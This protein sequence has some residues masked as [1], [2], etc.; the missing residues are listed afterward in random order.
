M[1]RRTFL[2]IGVTA[3]VG[4]GLAGCSGDTGDNASTNSPPPTQNPETATEAEPTEQTEEATEEPVDRPTNYRWDMHPGRNDQLRAWLNQYVKEPA[5]DVIQTHPAFEYSTESE[6]D[7]HE[8]DFEA[9][10]LFRESSFEILSRD[11][12][13]ENPLEEWVRAFVEEDLYA[14]EKREEF[15]RN[16]VNSPTEYSSEAWLNAETVEESLDL[17]HGLV[18][19]I[20]D[21]INIPEHAAVMREAYKRYHDFDVL[22]WETPNQGGVTPSGLM[23]SPDDDTLRCFDHSPSAHSSTSAHLHTPVEKCR[24]SPKATITIRC[25]STLTSGSVAMS[26]A[27]DTPKGWQLQRYLGLVVVVWI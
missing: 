7:D 2:R 20:G 4:V 26:T 19:T 8:I 24:L 9:L 17:G 27:S 13:V 22:A 6:R 16:D 23:Y 3:G 15:H 11:P 18:L 1:R 5:G 14:D 12:D 10:K 25:C 21:P